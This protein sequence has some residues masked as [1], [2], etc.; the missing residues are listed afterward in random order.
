MKSYCKGMS[1]GRELVADAYEE[2]RSGEAGRDNEWRVAQEYGSAD[3]LVDEIADEIGRRELALLPIRRYTHFEPT[4][5]KRREIGVES[6]KQ[7][8]VDHLACLCLEDLLRSRIGFYQVASIR[9]KGQLFAARR[10]DKWVRTCR[11][12]VHTD[13][14]KCYPSISPGLV[15]SILMRYVRSD[16]VLYVCMALL[17]TY[18]S[19]LEIGSYFSLRM[20]QLVL[21]FGYHH[22]ES[23]HKVRR[24]RSVRLLKHQL[25]YA[26]D[27][28]FFGDDKRDLKMALRS[29]ERFM[30][31]RLGLRLKPW[32]ICACGDDE[33]VDIVGYIVRPSRRTVRASIFLRARRS[34]SSFRRRPSLKSARRVCSYWGWFKNSDSR[35]FIS[36]NDVRETQRRARMTVSAAER[37][38]RGRKDVLGG[39]AREGSLRADRR[40]EHERMAPRKHSQ[41]CCG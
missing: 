33:P 36:R 20:A 14:T 10:I 22:V 18:G 21:S 27:V 5:G 40:R 29:L 30:S 38:N 13:V 25:W 6:V 7:Q 26:D 1:I 4:N 9:G 3:A 19:G 34:F 28:Y 15:M 23:L 24:G 37:R 35:N 39:K 11:Y 31:A 16:D 8:V 41:R 17:D 12:H 2:W 32:K